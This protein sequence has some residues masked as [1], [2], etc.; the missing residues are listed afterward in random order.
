MSWVFFVRKDMVEC[1]D[2]M[3]VCPKCKSANLGKKI[4]VDGLTEYYRIICSDC[5]HEYTVFPESHFQEE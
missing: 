2:V 5:K 4:E 1:E 3:E